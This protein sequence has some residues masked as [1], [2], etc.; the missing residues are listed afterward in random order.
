[1]IPH[2]LRTQWRRNPG[3]ISTDDM[4]AMLDYIEELEGKI[5][6]DFI[7]DDQTPEEVGSGSE[8]YIKLEAHPGAPGEPLEIKLK[9]GASISFEDEDIDPADKLQGTAKKKRW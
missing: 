6:V 8:T 5:P 3:S 9:N 4:M 1:M 2:T 7:S